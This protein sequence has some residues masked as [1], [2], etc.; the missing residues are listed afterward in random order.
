MLTPRIPQPVN[1]RGDL[2]Q[3]SDV[4]LA[5]RL[6]DAWRQFEIAED[7]MSKRPGWSSWS[8]S[9][10][11]GKRGP[12]RHPRVYRF[13]RALPN[14]FGWNWLG[15]FVGVSLAFIW[16]SKEAEPLLRSDAGTDRD[17]AL[18]EIQ[19]MMDEAERR[20]KESRTT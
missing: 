7:H 10:F 6:D 8:W 13:M 3:L 14:D 18:C 17:L 4:E 2:Y 5:Q 19:D 20:V 12:V 11:E 9:L 1:L 16:S 15:L